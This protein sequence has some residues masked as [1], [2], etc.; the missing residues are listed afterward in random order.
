MAFLGLF[1][2]FDKPGPGVS[3][4]EP[5]K[6]APIRFFQIF[7]R[8]FSKLVQ[9]NLIFVIPTV[10]VAILMV[11]LYLSPT[12]FFF[13]IP[14]AESSWEV[15]LWSMYV[16]PLPLILLWPFAAGLTYI[17]RNFAREEH[18]FV[19]SDFWDAVKGN[20][21]YFL[22]DGVVIYLSY[23][24]LS[25]ALIY[26]YA[27]A[28]T[29]S[30]FFVPFWFCIVLTVV[31]LFVQYYLPVILIT[32][33]LKFGQAFRNALIFT[34]AGFAR[35]IL[36]TVILGVIVLLIIGVIPIMPLTVTLLLMLFVFI[37]FSFVSFLVNF[38][39]YS[40]VDRYMIQPYEKQQYEEKYG[41]SEED[42]AFEKK[43]SGLFDD[44]PEEKE[45]E[46]EDKYV[47]VD[48]KLVKESQLKPSEKD[49]SD[50]E[51]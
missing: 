45:E 42:D 43:Y 39:V 31:S 18:A 28:M 34:V 38:T 46:K 24:V 1:G 22:L 6:A 41:G 3:K 44:A 37:F 26:Y 35:N 19:W 40:I 21:K 16:T 9:A 14:V 27:R 15:D 4:D 33:D 17:S 47:F 32:F 10:A 5:K 13:Q 23:F 49:I 8:K 51:K 50:S 12:H 11:L 48:G 30:I 20:W 2:N 25:F 36:L 29:N 7:F